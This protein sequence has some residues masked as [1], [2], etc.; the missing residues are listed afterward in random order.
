MLSTSSH[1]PLGRDATV[2]YPDV[3]LKFVNDTPHWLLLRTFVG[4]SSV[5]PLYGAPQPRRAAS[6]AA[7]LTLVSPPP[8]EKRLDPSLAPGTSEVQDPGESAYS[9]SVH[10]LVY[11]PN[12]KLLSD[13]TWLSNYVALP[14]ILLVGPKPKPKPKVKPKPIPTTT[15]PATRVAPAGKSARATALTPV[16]DPIVLAC[17]GDGADRLRVGHFQETLDRVLEPEARAADVEAARVDEQ[18]VVE[19]GRC[20]E[21]RVGLE[22]E[23]LDAEIAQPLVAA[24]EPLEELHTRHLEPDEVVRVVHDALRIGLGEA[25]AD[26]SG[27][28]VPLH[29]R[30]SLRP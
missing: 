1:Y 22:H 14:E 24:R 18:P 17:S 10:R 29:R 25:H 2:N 28:V 27:E 15:T 23:R 11:A 8:V 4:S 7:P 6:E 16:Y 5:L 30:N 13:A 19:D 21:A 3:D 26:L 12:G 20:D 9:T